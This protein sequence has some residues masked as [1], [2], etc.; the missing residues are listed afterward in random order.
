MRRLLPILLWIATPAGAIEPE[1]I[2]LRSTDPVETLVCSALIAASDFAGV[3][4]LDTPG[5]V[6]ANQ[7]FLDEFRP[8]RIV[9]VDSAGDLQRVLFPH[10]SKV[11]VGPRESRRSLF[12]A[13]ATAIEH[14]CPLVAVRKDEAAPDVPEIV[15]IGNGPSGTG[16]SLANGSQPSTFDTIVLANPA[17]G[18]LSSLAPL[19]AA[20]R[21]G[22]VALTSDD[23]SDAAAIVRALMNRVSCAE[24]G[25]LLILARP[26]SIRCE[27]RAN[28]AAGKDDS[29]EMEPLTP[30]DREAFSF[31]TGRLFHADPGIVALTLARA[32]LSSPRSR[33]R[34]ALVASNPGSSLDMLEAM[35]RTTAR[36]L[37]ACGYATTAIFGNQLTPGQLRQRLPECDVFLW[38]G[39]HNTLI[40]DWHF[41][42]WHEPLRPSVMVLQSCLALMEDKTSRL[43]ERGAIAVVGTSSRTYSASGGAFSL[44]YLDAIAYEGKT[45][46]GALRA[47]KNFLLCCSVLKEKRLGPTKLNGA[48]VRSAWAF[49]LWGDP[50]QSL[51]PPPSDTIDAVTCRV[52]GDSVTLHVPVETKSSPA[53]G[54]YRVPYRPNGRLAGLVRAGD[55][56][57]KELVPLAFAEV[58]LP[59]APAGKEPVLKT[60]LADGAWAFVWDARR[61]VGY[62]LVLPKDGGHD[63][64]FHVE[65]QAAGSVAAAASRR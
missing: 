8:S 9:A 63:L 28:P 15:A 46:G 51:P 42:D 59:S 24:A 5:A 43:F 58:P 48:V 18:G 61:K 52:S 11:V 50:T 49:S 35:S 27:V 54:K 41:A 14:R 17:D 34:T 55:D 44:A 31:A 10:A 47:S 29:I 39:H 45:L 26:E 13:A 64:K 33:A 2:V 20:R 38:E 4:L 53:G 30:H 7:R 3:F 6:A 37:Q 60:K 16:P 22:V 32:Q 65:W 25:N 56:D 1:A 23:G 21:K 19:V 40:K 62:L 36:E 12:A 57:G